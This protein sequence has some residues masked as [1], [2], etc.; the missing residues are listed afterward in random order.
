MLGILF[1]AVGLIVVLSPLVVQP[2]VS[3]EKIYWV[4][5]VAMALGLGLVT[6]YQGTLINTDE[7]K[8]RNYISVVGIKFGQ[9]IPLPMISKV[10]VI[11]STSR[12]TNI[13]NGIS[14]TFSG[15]ITD[16][17]VLIYEKHNAKPFLRFSFNKKNKALA[18]ADSLSKLLGVPKDAID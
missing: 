11:S 13:P 2:R 6:T 15:T 18:K 8:F 4:G 3:L 16:Y 9:W 12:R 17:S 10:K 14:P 7:K 5:V 1:V